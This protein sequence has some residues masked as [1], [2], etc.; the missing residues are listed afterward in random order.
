MGGRIGNSTT[1]SNSALK[2]SPENSVF[3]SLST[4]RGNVP[5]YQAPYILI[6]EKTSWILSSNSAGEPLHL[7]KNWLSYGFTQNRYSQ[8]HNSDPRRLDIP[9]VK[10]RKFSIDV[11]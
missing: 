2:W 3:E 5:S 1:V 9:R 6:A 10:D 7:L 8:F 4:I 11:S